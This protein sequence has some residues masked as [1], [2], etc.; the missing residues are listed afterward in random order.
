MFSL[1]SQEDLAEDWRIV[2][3]KRYKENIEIDIY[4]SQ[5]PPHVWNKLPMHLWNILP[6]DNIIID[7]LF[8]YKIIKTSHDNKVL[9]LYN[10]IISKYKNLK[11]IEELY[12]YCLSVNI[13]GWIMI[14]TKNILNNKY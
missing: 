7:K 8:K 2:M 3:N 13:S 9:D 11:V 14:K 4:L 5:L 1:L 12:K 10:E 6:N